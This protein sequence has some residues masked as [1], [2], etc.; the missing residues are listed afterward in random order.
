MD[1]V[2][3]ALV[4]AALFGSMTVALRFALVHVPDAEAGALLTIVA[5]FA[6]TLPFVAAGELDLRGT[7]PFLLAGVLGPGGS[8]LLFTL[9]VRDAGPS[10]SS[11]TV[12]TAPLVS[13][14]IALVLL[15]E[16][17]KAGVLGGALLIVVGGIVLVRE[18]G[19]PEHVKWIGLGF[20]FA[21]A[22]L[23]AVRDN[24]VR[25]L[26]LDTG[27]QPALAVA[28]T[29]FAGGLTVAAWLLIT[30]RRLPSRGLAAF[31]PAGLCFGL[32]YL[33]L[34]EAFY[35]GR[36]SVVSPLVATESL[37]G[38]GLSALLLRRHE[39]VG[40]RLFGGAVLV[41]TG[42]ILIGLFR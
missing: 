41:V 17:A 7:W 10:R 21:A 31:V 24:V 18:P 6:V 39:L 42:G 13:V 2:V 12:G 38:V 29:L 20:A 22:I 11:M 4:S 25:D 15:D 23:I 5:A 28:A 40:P 37:W 26:S 8:Q 9:A 36:V 14:A 33:C 3:L 16:P 34:V 30:R 27:V 32:S 35:R 1:A 19:R